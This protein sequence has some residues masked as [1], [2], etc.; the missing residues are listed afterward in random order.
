[1]RHTMTGLFFRDFLADMPL[2]DPVRYTFEYYAKYPAL[3]LVHWPPFFHFIEA[4]FFLV[5]G[6]SIRTAHLAT[7]SF[8]VLGVYCWYR[9]AERQGPRYRAILSAFIFPLMPAVLLY[10]RGTMLEV[11]LLSLSLGTIYLWHRFLESG[12]GRHLW[13]MAAFLVAALLTGQKAIFL[14]FFLGLHWLV[15][16][17]FRL[18]LRWDVWAA[19]GA[20]LAVVLPWYLFTFRMLSLSYERAL[21]QGFHH[22][23]KPIHWLFYFQMLPH[24]LGLLL[25][26]L[27]GAGFGWAVLTNARRYRFFIVWIVSCYACFTLIQEKEPRHIM[28]WI[29]PLVYFALLA[30]EVLFAYRRWCLVASGALALYF[31]IGAVRYERVPEVAGIEEVARYVLSQPDSDVIY[32]QGPLN[33]DFIFYV[34]KFDPEKRHLVARGKQVVA[35]RI[36]PQFGTREI[37]KT[38]EEVLAFFRTWGIRYAVVENIEPLAGMRV[39]KNALDSD[40]FELLRIFPLWTNAP[41]D[42]N[43]KVLVYRYRGQTQRTHEP[44]VIPMMTLRNDI[45]A[46]LNRLAG[47]PWPN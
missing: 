34:R 2:K 15:E 29:P 14:I 11:P 10:E 37:L 44:V 35:S 36:M 25:T 42:A 33:G 32:Y 5:F 21:G 38:P 24:Q 12:S 45:R 28:V 16:R 19:L 22:L 4:I 47:R 9:V 18:L 39:V 46:D 20:V 26:C 7:L 3:G 41:E 31:L 43:R 13:G 40:N 6:I 23:T 1:M 30:V 27:A 17:R 8:V